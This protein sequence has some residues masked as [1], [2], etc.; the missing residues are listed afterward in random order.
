[1]FLPGNA[2]RECYSNG[3]WEPLTNYTGC[4]DLMQYP[5]DH[6]ES[7]SA[8]TSYYSNTIYLVGYLVSLCALSVAILIFMY[9]RR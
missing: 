2:S 4:K 6:E 7:I 9:H 5:V 1:M 3:T 8:E